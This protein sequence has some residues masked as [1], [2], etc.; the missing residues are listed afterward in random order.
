MRYPGNF[1]EARSIIFENPHG[2]KVEE[3]NLQNALAALKDTAKVL[4]TEA[5]SKS[6]GNFAQLVRVSI[7]FIYLR[8]ILKNLISGSFLRSYE[9]TNYK[10]K[11]VTRVRVYSH[12]C[13][14]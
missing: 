12:I 3:S 14:S 1:V 2:V 4:T 7:P 11:L 13:N 8:I 5:S 6:A 9:S 10:D